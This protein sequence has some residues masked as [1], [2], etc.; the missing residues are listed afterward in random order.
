MKTRKQSTLGFTV[1]LSV[2]DSIAEFATLAGGE[3]AVLEMAIDEEVF[4]G[5]LP[6]FRTKFV[7]ALEKSEADGGTGVAR[8]VVGKG[9]KNKAGEQADLFEKD[10]AYIKRVL[11]SADKATLQKLAQSVADGIKFDPSESSSSSGRIGKKYITA[12]EG[13]TAAINAGAST[14]DTFMANFIAENPDFEFEFDAEGVPTLES[15]AQA[16]RADELRLASAQAN[17]FLKATSA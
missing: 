16:M 5:W 13:I 10:T 2:P 15:V 8:Q 1:G 9:P 17:K 7:T 14:W 11:A 6:V 12:A 3:N 4:R